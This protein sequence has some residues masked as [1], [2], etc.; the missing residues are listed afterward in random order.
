[1]S[2]NII[3][4]R[5]L[6][7]QVREALERSEQFGQVP[8]H[9]LVAFATAIATA[10]KAE[11]VAY[12]LWMRIDNEMYLQWPIAPTRADIENDLCMYSEGD[13]KLSAIRPLFTA[14]VAS[15]GEKK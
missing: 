3:V 2:D 9:V 5:A 15:E 4:S 10:E 8:Q 14:P 7:E 13:R 6:L 12:G 11:P 1:M